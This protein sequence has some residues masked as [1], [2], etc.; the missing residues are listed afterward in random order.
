[1]AASVPTA[2]VPQEPRLELEPR[3]SLNSS[4]DNLFY[5]FLFEVS[6]GGNTDYLDYPGLDNDPVLVTTFLT[7]QSTP[8]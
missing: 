2:N 3:T 8:P 6:C 5:K 1:M 4:S 7:F